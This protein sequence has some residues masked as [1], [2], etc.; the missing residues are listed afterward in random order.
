VRILAALVLI[1]SGCS[2]GVDRPSEDPHDL[3]TAHVRLTEDFEPSG[4]GSHPSWAKAEWNPLTRRAGGNLPYETRFKILHSGKGIYVLMDGTDSRLS[5]TGRKDFAHLWEEDVYEVFLCPDPATPLYFE[6]EISPMDHELPLLV[7]NHR[8]EF[9]GW[10]PWHYEGDRKVRKAV[11]VSGG[12][13][14]PG[15]AV[16]GW[17]AEMFI[18][19]ELFRGLSN[20]PP[21]PGSRW[22]ANFYR[23][24]YDQGPVTQWHW[25]PVGPSFHEYWNFGVLRF[26]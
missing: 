10:I 4:D 23:M 20:V 3:V 24:D 14:Q 18:P 21:A 6:Y 8:G 9:M 26:D 16:T 25:A 7:P 1:T 12:P 5:T 2:Q 19:F 17:R 13:R 15:A 11:T 22:R